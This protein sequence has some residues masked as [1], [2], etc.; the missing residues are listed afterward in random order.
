MM[1]WVMADH[2][3]RSAVNDPGPLRE[4]MGLLRAASMLH[5][6]MFTLVRG[7]VSFGGVRL[8]LTH[9][10]LE[11]VKLTRS[12]LYERAREEKCDIAF[13]GHTHEPDM[14]TGVPM[15]VNPGAVC[16]EQMAMLEV[17]DGRPRV[18]MLVF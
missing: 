14:V 15:L 16:R 10:H 6:M 12:F 5:N 7:V 4:A 8:Y 11:R 18:K 3:C 13:Y 9:G 17:E 1:L 2:A